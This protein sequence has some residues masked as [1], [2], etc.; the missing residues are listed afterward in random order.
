M[1]RSE[2][3]GR[4]RLPDNER[5]H[6]YSVRLTDIERELFEKEYGSVQKAVNDFI[7]KM[8]VKLKRKSK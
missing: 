6:N 4:P 2:T 3:R 8:Y 7:K 5:K 1:P